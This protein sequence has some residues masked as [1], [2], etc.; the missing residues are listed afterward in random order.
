MCQIF[1]SS[2]RL[3]IYTQEVSSQIS[4]VKEV[5]DEVHLVRKAENLP[6]P[7]GGLS[8]TDWLVGLVKRF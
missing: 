8:S 7:I 5:G 4:L 6:F 1:C 2:A 3:D